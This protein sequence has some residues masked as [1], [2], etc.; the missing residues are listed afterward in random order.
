MGEDH[1]D[2]YKE[3]ED[4]NLPKTCHNRVD[5]HIA[6]LKE[7]EELENAEDTNQS[8]ASYHDHESCTMQEETEIDR[9]DRQQIH[10]AE[11][12]VRR[13]VRR[14]YQRL[15]D[16]F[17]IIKLECKHLRELIIGRKPDAPRAVARSRFTEF[18]GKA[19]QVCFLH[20]AC[21]VEL[22]V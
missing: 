6:F 13:S 9:Q 3:K 17:V 19:V 1:H 18:G 20:L 4:K 16:L 15:V 12:T 7:A 11:V 10:N 2:H 21:D 8:D 22:H 14:R 5:Q